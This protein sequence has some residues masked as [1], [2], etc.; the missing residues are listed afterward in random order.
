MDN[1]SS[2]FLLAISTKVF[3]TSELFIGFLLGV[4][5]SVSTLI[6]KECIKK[7]KIKKLIQL[8]HETYIKPVIDSLESV[9]VN[10]NLNKNDY[11]YEFRKIS[12][13]IKSLTNNIEFSL[14]NEYIALNSDYAF[15]LIRIAEFTKKN[16]MYV[17]KNI[18]HFVKIAAYRNELD[19]TLHAKKNIKNILEA[20]KLNWA[21]NTNY[22]YLKRLDP[23]SESNTKNN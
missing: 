3:F 16:L 11:I 8:H 5:P 2:I 10:E 4:I 7:I 23:F 14:N 18:D 20:I 17:N 6:Y 1:I 15:E 22:I 21:E 19:I 13:E 9:F 12:N